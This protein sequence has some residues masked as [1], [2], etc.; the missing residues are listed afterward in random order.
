MYIRETPNKEI[1]EHFKKFIK[2][3]DARVVVGIHPKKNH[4]KH[5]FLISQYVISKSAKGA[6]PLVHWEYTK[7]IE[8]QKTL[9]KANLRKIDLREFPSSSTSLEIQ[10]FLFC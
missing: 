4:K 3:R 9:T 6:Q 7:G 5:F 1:E 10:L 2:S 8:S